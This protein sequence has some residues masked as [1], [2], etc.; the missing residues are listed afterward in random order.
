MVEPKDVVTALFG[1]QVTFS[2]FGVAVLALAVGAGG[3]AA[4]V[5]RFRE[6]RTIEVLA[7]TVVALTVV[8]NGTGM[9]ASA[10]WL[11][12]SAEHLPWAVDQAY[13]ASVGLFFAVALLIT[14]ATLSAGVA[15]LA[16]AI[17]ATAG[18]AVKIGGRASSAVA[19]RLS[20][21]QGVKR[22]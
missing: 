11:V 4:I 18:I 22:Q 1:A 17:A 7:L 15:V 12:G 10:Y 9:V 8:L 16:P 6:R 5:A 21:P 3:P 2:A 19:R 13:W 20:R 14:V